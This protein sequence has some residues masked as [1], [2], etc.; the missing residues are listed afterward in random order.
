VPVAN[1]ARNG[2]KI[3]RIEVCRHD[4]PV[5]NGPY[6]MVNAEVHALDGTLVKIVTD[7]AIAGWGE[8]SPSARPTPRPTPIVNRRIAASVTW[9]C[10]CAAFPCESTASSPLL[11]GLDRNA[12]IA[13]P[14]AIRGGG[15]HFSGR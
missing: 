2:L 10:E 8:I 12:S 14:V 5:V 1:D 3:E 15:D 4:L 13:G 9:S 6:T 7:N 11:G